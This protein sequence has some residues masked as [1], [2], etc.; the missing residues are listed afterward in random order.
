VEQ[1]NPDYRPG[2]HKKGKREGKN[3]EMGNVSR[4]TKFYHNG[5]ERGKND[6]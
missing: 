2:N 5:G 4:S 1:K 3:P 6:E